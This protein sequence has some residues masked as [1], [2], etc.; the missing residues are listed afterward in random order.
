MAEESHGLFQFPDSDDL[1]DEGPRRVRHVVARSYEPRETTDGWFHDDTQDVAE[2]FQAKQ[3]G[4]LVLNAIEHRFMRRDYAGALAMCQSWLSENGKLDKPYKPNEVLDIASRC[5]LRLGRPAEALAVIEQ[6]QD[7]RDPGLQFALARLLRLNG[8]HAEAIVWLLGYLDQRLTDY[9]AWAEISRCF[10]GL[11][12][13]GIA[14]LDV[15]QMHAWAW[16]AMQVSIFYLDRIPRP[17]S[18]LASAFASAGYARL[19]AEMD[20][21]PQ[22]DGRSEHALVAA[23]LEPRASAR[24]VQ[25]ISE[26][27]HARMLAESGAGDGDAAHPQESEERGAR[28]M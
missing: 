6:V 9:A 26:A 11:A 24:L 17:D 16:T 19:R 25:R 3:G 4:N 5:A 13:S 15:D 7:R 22:R 1:F 10:A 23:G 2:R 20:A 27:M 14:G 21:L 12:S 8:R 28:D 18:E